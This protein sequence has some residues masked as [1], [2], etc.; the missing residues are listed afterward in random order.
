M[1]IT[2]LANKWSELLPEEADENIRDLAERTEEGWKD[3]TGVILPVP[4][5]NPP[6]L[7]SFWPSWLR[8]ELAFEVDD[9][10]FCSAYHMN[11]DV[12][13]WGKIYPHIHWSTSWT[14][15]NSVK[16]EFQISRAK[17]HD[18]EFFWAAETYTV[19]TQPNQTVSWAWRHYVSEVS[20]NDALTITEP[21]ELIL[22]TVKR[23]SNWATDNTDDVFW[24]TVDLHYE[25]ERDTTPNK[26]PNFYN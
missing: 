17:W 23:L 25:A 9:F 10:A 20:D 21:D 5:S 7:T 15:T 12:K 14:D 26:A 8:K 19:E 13:V 16:W 18:Q 4:S 24:L 22:I 2:L 6:T 11:H 1:T 3:L